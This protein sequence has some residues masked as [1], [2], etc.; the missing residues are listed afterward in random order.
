[1]GVL[2]WAL[3]CLTAQAQSSTPNVPQSTS[4]APSTTVIWAKTTPTPSAL[5]ASSSSHFPTNPIP[6]ELAERFAKIDASIA[7][8]SATWRHPVIW[9]AIIA[10]IAA[11]YGQFVSAKNARE[12]SKQEAEA[13]L[14]QA[15]QEARFRQIEKIIEFRVKQL[16][17][18]YGPMHAYLEQSKAIYIKINSIL[19][20]TEPDK[21]RELEKSDPLG[22]RFLIFE[23]GSWKGF[24]LLDRLPDVYRNEEA[25]PLVDRVIEIG[26]AI[27]K[28]ISKNSGLADRHLMG[29]LGEYSAHYEI[30]KS[31]YKRKERE[32]YPPGWHTIGY[33]PRRLNKLID[34]G[35]RAVNR[36]INAYSNALH[37]LLEK[38]PHSTDEPKDVSLS[39][40]AYNSAYYMHNASIFVD[41]TKDV[42]MDDLRSRFIATLPSQG[43]ILDAGCGSGRDT[44]AFI[45]SGFTVTAIDASPEIA[46]LA[47]EIAGVSCKVE[48]FEEMSYDKVFDGIWACASLLHIPKSE[49]TNILNRFANALKPNGVLYVS[50]KE[51]EGENISDDGRFFSYYDFSEFRKILEKTGRY[52]IMDSWKQE[53]EDSSRHKRNF[54]NYL[55]KRR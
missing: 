6:I 32:A 2:A 53:S 30:L 19:A 48:S 24:R 33:Y 1:M 10:G 50:L 7:Q 37:E 20:K 49:V 54:L 47:T 36:D 11:L 13:A 3:V 39:P 31:V 43:H 34:Q 38:I 26:A 28:T 55:A 23:G 45:L 42:D 15:E 9:A 17:R 46:S 41:A 51:G 4:V 52:E 22:Y 14:N 16:E 44:R 8:L 18:F 25:A 35:Y 5:S 40:S 12:Q 27:S 29:A 21:Y